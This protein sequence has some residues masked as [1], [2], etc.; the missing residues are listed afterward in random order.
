MLK[1]F[2]KYFLGKIRAMIANV[3]CD[4]ETVRKLG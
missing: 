2:V 3:Q 1:E 4:G